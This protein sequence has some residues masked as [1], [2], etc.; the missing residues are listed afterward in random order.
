MFTWYSLDDTYFGMFDEKRLAEFLSNELK[1]NSITYS[2]FK[3]NSTGKKKQK[4]K[5]TCGERNFWILR[6]RNGLSSIALTEGLSLGLR[7]KSWPKRAR[8]S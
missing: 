8:R 1:H 4:K 6:A 3:E 7:L 2:I 5:L